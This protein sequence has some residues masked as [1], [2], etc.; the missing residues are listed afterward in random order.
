MDCGWTAN[1]DLVREPLG[2][3]PRHGMGRRVAGIGK[4][5]RKNKIVLDGAVES[6]LD[7]G[8]RKNGMGKR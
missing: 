7:A 6:R 5:K 3:G 8:M 1:S 4:S 2:R